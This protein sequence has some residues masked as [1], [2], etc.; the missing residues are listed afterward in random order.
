MKIS[1]QKRIFLVLEHVILAMN[2]F[3]NNFTCEDV[4]KIQRAIIK[5]IGASSLISKSES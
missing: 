5:I 3:S 4:E 1:Y 2:N